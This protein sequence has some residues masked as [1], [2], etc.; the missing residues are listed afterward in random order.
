MS[1]KMRKNLQEEY[2]RLKKALKKVLSPKREESLPQLVL[3]P[4]KNR[5][6]FER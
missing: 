1:D 4:Y 5:Q 2:N 6:R 3:Q